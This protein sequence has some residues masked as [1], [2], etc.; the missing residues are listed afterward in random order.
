MSKLNSRKFY[1]AC[2][3]LAVMAVA[4]FCGKM[5][6]GEFATGWLGVLTL[7]YGANVAQKKLIEG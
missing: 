2:A 1:L 6:G 7:Y 3:S 4:L 5:S